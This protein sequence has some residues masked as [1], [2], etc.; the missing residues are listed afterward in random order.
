MLEIKNQIVEIFREE[1]ATLFQSVKIKNAFK[2]IN[3]CTSV[4]NKN[5]IKKLVVKTKIYVF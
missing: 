2:N 4:K 5:S 1:T 3:I